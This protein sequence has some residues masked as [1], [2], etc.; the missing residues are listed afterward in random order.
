MPTALPPRPDL[1]Q[2]RRRAK[3]LRDSAH[4]SLATAQLRVAREYGFASWPKLKAA[5]EGPAVRLR[6]AAEIGDAATVAAVLAE[7]PAA[8]TAPDD[9]LGWP[10][11]LHLAYSR[12]R[13]GGVGSGV[14]SAVDRRAAMVETARLLLD[15]GADP[16][17]NNGGRPGFDYRS[18]LHGSVVS[19]QPGLTALLLERG[20][21]AG[22][23]ITVREAAERGDADSVRRLLDHGATVRG[24]WALEAA[25]HNGH[26]EAVRLLLE[27]EQRETGRPAGERAGSLLADAAGCSPDVV[28]VLLDAGADPAARDDD[29][30]S[31]VRRATRAGYPEVAAALV[32]RGAPD[33]TTVFD[34][35]LGA[36][37]RGDRVA[38]RSWLAADPG[39]MES[40]SEADRAA[41]VDVAQRAPTADPVGLMLEIG[42]P[43]GAR[44]ENGETP[45][46]AAAYA[47]KAETVR[48]LL[49][50]G[51]EVDALDTAFE[52]TPL[53]FATVGSGEAGGGAG[54]WAGTVQALLDAGASR[55]GVWVEGKPPS[56]EVAALLRRAGVPA[57]AAA[58]SARLNAVPEEAVADGSAT[59]VGGGELRELAEALLAAYEQRDIDGFGALLSPDVHWGAGPV[60]CT[61][62]AQVLTWYQA[63]FGGGIRVVID[64][65]EVLDDRIVVD[66]RWGRQPA[67]ARPV[68]LEP[69]RQIFHV[70]DGEIVEITGAPTGPS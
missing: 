63:A 70:R 47:G 35:L 37:R 38:A 69:R 46:H 64:A 16:A 31:A 34:Q 49:D 15:A 13:S 8:A 26:A 4:I 23:R 17:S 67:D 33:D 48:L 12:R 45:L 14:E 25:V 1:A 42:F 29:G 55:D 22:D 3:E 40:L 19:G 24:T 10:P 6:R 57:P 43:V 28:A 56:D 68:A 53:A 2:L 36:C 58:G 27:A 65:V 50:A 20:A 51:A 18:A 11:L 60:G 30:M 5:V 61:N 62:K 66:L 39:L 52:A 9:E 44:N 41:I 32:E 54:D 59:I 7:D 21:P